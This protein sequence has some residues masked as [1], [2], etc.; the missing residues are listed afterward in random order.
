MSQDP[1][2]PSGQGP[3]GAAG[4]LGAAS[5]GAPDASEAPKAGDGAPSPAPDAPEEEAEQPQDAWSA[6]R[7]LYAH[8]PGIMVGASARFEGGLSGRDQH[9]VSGGHVVGDV[10]MG[11]KTEIYQLGVSSDAHTSGLVPQDSLDRTAALF[12]PGGDGSVFTGLV[13]RL[14]TE[15]VLVLSGQHFTGRRTAALMLLNRLGATP[16]RSLDRDTTPAALAGLL[17][18][19][20]GHVLCDLALR[21]DLPLRDTHL[22]ALRER[23][24]EQDAYLVITVDPAAALED[25]SVAHWQP[26]QSRA[27]LEAHLAARPGGPPGLGAEAGALL[28]HRAV[29]EFLDRGHQ[30]REVAAFARLLARVATGR[31]AGHEL[32]HFSLAALESQVEE[33]FGDPSASLSDKAFL[34]SLA[35]FN[36]APYALTAELSDVLYALL[37]KTEDPSKPPLVPV[38]GNAA[39]GRLNRARA[40]RYEENEVTEWGP[41]AQRKARYRDDRAALVLLREVWTGHPSARPALV[42]WLDRLADD[43]RP[44]VRTRAASTAAVLAAADLPSAMALVITR[45][46]TSRRYRQRLVA[47]NAL[48]LAHFLGAPNILRILDSWCTGGDRRERWTAIRTY[49]L[50]GP[51]HPAEALLALRSAARTHFAAGDGRGGDTDRLAEEVDELSSSVALL[52]LSPAGGQVLAEME[53]WLGDEPALRDLALRAFLYACAHPQDDDPAESPAPLLEWYAQAAAA[54]APQAR[55]L[56]DLW[57]AALRDRHHTDDALAVLRAWTWSADHAPRAEAAL[58]ALLT[59]LV[60]TDTDRRRL[61][62]LL[63]TMPA[64]DGGTTPPPV[65]GR[66]LAVVDP[67]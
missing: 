39:G 67:G 43:G 49:A 16:V 38:F 28:E 44:L 41:V 11:S 19:A 57:T 37:Q 32:E 35:A 34:V 22:L 26:P 63:R 58:A 15:R 42:A 6:R 7:D 64:E 30:L 48:T 14:R 61:A 47:V 20:R 25:V 59:D 10:I 51:A 62:H 65:A 36:E 4:T 3:D 8:S 45:W 18:G 1:P 12:V 50:I 60:E 13:E 46:A 53:S 55:D 27:V 66:L 56:T 52:L 21:R 23:L 5:G 9:G 31:A 54:R 2:G 33:W 24:V 40:E 29:K 17:D